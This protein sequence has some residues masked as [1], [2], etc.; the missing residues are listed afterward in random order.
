MPAVLALGKL[1]E[2]RPDTL[3]ISAAVSGVPGPVGIGP[4]G[5]FNPFLCISSSD[6]CVTLG[7]VLNGACT[8]G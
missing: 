3:A 1:V 7:G 6:S 8:D 2:G 4:L 5:P